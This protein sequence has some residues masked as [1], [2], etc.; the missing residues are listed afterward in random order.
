MA[1]IFNVKDQSLEVGSKILVQEKKKNKSIICEVIKN[2]DGYN[3]KSFYDE[4]V[5]YKQ[6]EKS[7]E[8]LENRIGKTHRYIKYSKE[9]SKEFNK[10][11]EEVK[12]MER[13]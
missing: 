6:S 9:A 4:E 13:C 10:I 3:L 11:K 5:I 2:E 8:D 1:A 7:I 12:E